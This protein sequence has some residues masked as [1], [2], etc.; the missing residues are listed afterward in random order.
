MHN[1]HVIN[2]IV[3]CITMISLTCWPTLTIVAITSGL[4]A[5]DVPN[6]WMLKAATLT[7]PTESALTSVAT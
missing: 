3:V 4:A 7:G 2:T 5:F 6:I 1:K